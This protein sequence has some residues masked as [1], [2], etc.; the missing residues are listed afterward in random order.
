M[1]AHAMAGLALVIG[2]VVLFSTA[3]AISSFITMV[4]Y[5]ESEK[6]WIRKMEGTPVIITRCKDGERVWRC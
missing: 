2:G 3:M 1:Q 6:P 4:V 5:T